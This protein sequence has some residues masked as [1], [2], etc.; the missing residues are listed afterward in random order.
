MV[1]KVSHILVAL[2]LS[3]TMIYVSGGVAIVR[4]LHS[5]MVA[6]LLSA[7][8]LDKDCCHETEGDEHC[9][10]D[11]RTSCLQVTIEKLSP[12]STVASSSLPM[13][14][15]LALLPTFQQLMLEWLPSH[16]ILQ[17]SVFYASIGIKPPPKIYLH[18]LCT[19]LI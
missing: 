17:P 13:P 2:F 12:A 8:T 18:T 9:C 3:L 15:I 4:C 14:V 11:E 1:K 19:L 5:D 10:E 6:V 7:D 16:E